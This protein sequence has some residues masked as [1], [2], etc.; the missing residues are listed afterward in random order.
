MKNVSLVKYGSRPIHRVSV[1]FRHGVVY[2]YMAN[3]DCLMSKMLDI[4]ILQYNLV[5][6]MKV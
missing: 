1:F 6:I 4:I 3:T 2:G 5:I